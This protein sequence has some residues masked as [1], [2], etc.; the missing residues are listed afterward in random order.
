MTFIEEFIPL[1]TTPRAERVSLPAFCY[2]CRRAIAL[3][4]IAVV[5]AV[6]LAVHPLAGAGAALIP[7]QAPGFSCVMVGDF[8]ITAIFHGTIEVPLDK[9]LQRE[10]VA[11]I[12]AMMKSG[13]EALPA[14][15]SI[16]AFVINTGSKLLTGAGDLSKPGAV[17][18][19]SRTS[20]PPT[21]ART[22]S[23]PCCSRT[24]TPTIPAG[25]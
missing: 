17:A 2:A 4:A 15:T 25:L 1:R 24:C 18:G 13:F 14:E 10:S 8:E 20:S 9:L 23:M 5:A 11:K 7:A 16:N 12:A 19:C 22:R 3:S 6:G 21:T